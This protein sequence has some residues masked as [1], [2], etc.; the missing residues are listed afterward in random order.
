MPD[1]H[2][3]PPRP[4]EEAE[5]PLLEFL[6]AHAG[7]RQRSVDDHMFAGGSACGVPSTFR[8]QLFTAPGR[9]PVA[10]A[11]QDFDEGVVSLTNGAERYVRRV[12]EQYAPENPEPPIWIERYVDQEG[13]LASDEFELVTFSMDGEFRAVGWWPISPHQLA[14]L[15]G[16]AVDGSRGAGYRPRP[17]PPEEALQYKV[18]AVADLPEP[19]PFRE[20]CMGATQSILD[21]VR[22]RTSCCW[23]HQQNWSRV[24]ELAVE[25]VESARGAGKT[26]REIS[27]QR[28]TL[29]SE[30]GVGP[31]DRPALDSLLSPA[32]GIVARLGAN[33]SYTNGNHR[34]RAMKDAGVVRTV[35]T[36]WLPAETVQRDSSDHDSP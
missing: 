4:D 15:V 13:G 1:P 32:V 5:G 14:K 10:V 28:L 11:T 24:S 18:V 36:T 17:S 35:V 23:Y 12:W 34:A 29:A 33:A 20:S 21:R 6:R 19:A 26:D 30:L 31:A 8:L 16:T 9:R 27:D 22:R 2:P 25:L 3:T 7:P